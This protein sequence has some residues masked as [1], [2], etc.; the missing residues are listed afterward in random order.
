MRRNV[1]KQWRDFNNMNNSSARLPELNCYRYDTVM[2]KSG[3]VLIIW[4]GLSVIIVVWVFKER[5]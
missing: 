3:K 2:K 1:K 5:G 4:A